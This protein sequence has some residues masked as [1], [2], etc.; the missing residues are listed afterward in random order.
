M[1]SSRNLQQSDAKLGGTLGS[2]KTQPLAILRPYV[3]GTGVH[4]ATV[5]TD[6]LT[7]LSVSSLNTGTPTNNMFNNQTY[8]KYIQVQKKTQLNVNV[9]AGNYIK[10][11]LNCHPRTVPTQK[12]G[13]R[14][15]EYRCSWHT[16]G[17]WAIADP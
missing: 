16:G 3:K 2:R 8:I 1:P 5:Q 13:T 9:K 12:I 10:M 11:S 4:V 6:S 17:K 14:K 7:K 15:S